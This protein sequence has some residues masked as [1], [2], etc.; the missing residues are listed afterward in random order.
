MSPHRGRA[1]ATLTA[2]VALWAATWAVNRSLVRV[3][4]GS[5]RPTL[6]P[7]T[8]L[9]TVPATPRGPAAGRWLRP[10]RVVVVEDPLAP[11]HL[12]VKRIARIEGEG[13]R[14]RV[15]VLGDDLD[16]STD[17]RHWGPLPPAAVRGV[18]VAR[19]PSLSRAGLR[20]AST[21]PGSA[22]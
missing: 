18:A 9:L 1:A 15:V 2:L 13:L 3:R 12:V 17:S 4:G 19:W 14:T 16:E 21:G 20:G 10:G 7:G 22:R 8:L 6:P 5:M 11:G